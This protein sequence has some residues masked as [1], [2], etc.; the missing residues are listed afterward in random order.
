MPSPMRARWCAVVASI[1]LV[2][3]VVSAQSSKRVDGSALRN[4]TKNGEDWITDG[5]AQF[6]T[7]FSPLTQINATNVARLGLAWST[8]TDSP[9][10]GRL[11]ATPLMA[12]GVLYTSLAWDVIVATDARTRRVKWRWDPEIRR[13]HI[14][15]LCCGPVNRGVALYEGRLYAGLLDGRLVALNQDT[16]QVLWEV[17]TTTNDETLITGALRVVKGKVRRPVHVNR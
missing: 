5:R 8:E 1:P 17:K 15:E 7:H 12:N 4:A 3:W 6:E 11:Q 2:G 13:Q 9:S 10:G 16:G 14:S